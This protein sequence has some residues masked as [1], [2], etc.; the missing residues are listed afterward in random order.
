[1]ERC[2]VNKNRPVWRRMTRFVK[3]KLLY[4]R[5]LEQ[6]PTKMV[7]SVHNND[8]SIS[9]IE[10]IKKWNEKREKN[11]KYRIR[12]LLEFLEFHMRMLGGCSK[13]S[14]C[15]LFITIT[16]G[17]GW[18]QYGRYLTKGRGLHELKN[19]NISK[20]RSVPG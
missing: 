4:D 3:L 12:F 19:G 6:Y 8:V 17:M 16:G 10:Q 7:K 20:N 1:M 13:K 2:P 18:N 11:L 9:Y 15:L 14:W 5:F